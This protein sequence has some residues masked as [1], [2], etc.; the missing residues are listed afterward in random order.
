MSKS[1]RNFIIG[2]GIVSILFALYGV[3]K[4]GEFI[5]ALSGIVIGA[6][7]IGAVLIEQNK[8]KK[9]K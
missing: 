7:L 8:N 6:S 2:I 4:G 3:F 5:D 9:A 1:L